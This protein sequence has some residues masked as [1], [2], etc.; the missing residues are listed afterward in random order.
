MRLL[1]ASTFVL[2]A[3]ALCGALRAQD[4]SHERGLPLVVQYPAK[5]HRGGSQLFSVAQHPSGRLYLGAL[6]G[7]LTYDG[8]SWTAHELPNNS[9]VFV[10]ATGRGGDVAIGGVGE[11]GLM[12]EQGVYRSLVP[13]L[14]A[15]QRE[16]GD[17]RGICATDYGFLFVTERGL[18]DWN[19]RAP[20]VVADFT[21]TDQPP[22]RCHQAG[23]SIYLAGGRG[24]YRVDA[25]T[26]RLVPWG[27]ENDRVEAVIAADDS[28]VVVAVQDKGLFITDG[29]LAI[30]FAPAA[31]DFLR[32]KRIS[33]GLR[34]RDGRLAISTRQ[35][36]IVI[37]RRDGTID[38]LIGLS[39]GISS[40]A[41]V[42]LAEDR[43]G[44]LWLA[45]HGP[46]E[47]IELSTAATRLDER[48]GLQ[49]HPHGI[50]RHGNALY[51]ATTHGL[52]ALERRDDPKATPVRAIPEVRGATRSVL[53]FDDQLLA[54]GSD[55]VAIRD[56]AG[57]WS[58]LPELK[59]DGVSSLLRST[60]DPAL[61]WVT[62]RTGLSAIRHEAGRWRHQGVVVKRPYIRSLLERDG[63]LWCGTIF[64]G[65]LR[66][67]PDGTVT[68]IGKGETE[69][70]VIGGQLVVVNW[71]R[72][73]MRVSG[74]TLLPDPRLTQFT[75]EFMHL[76]EDAAGNVWSGQLP[77]RMARKL[78][79]GSYARELEPLDR[80]DPAAIATLDAEPDGVIWFGTD[81]GLFRYDTRM[82]EAAAMTQA[83]VQ[84]APAIHRAVTADD[85]QV[86]G[87]LPASFGRLHIEFAPLSYRRG[88]TYQ[89]R[90]DPVD[91]AWS[92]P[93]GGSF[94]DYTN[95]GAG[96]YTFR[97]RASSGPGE[98]SAETQ[99]K[100]SVAPAWYRTPWALAL[101]AIVIGVLVTVI[102]RLR[103][104]ALHRQ[105]ERLR[106]LVDDRTEEMQQANA[107][108]E[109]LSLLDD[110]TAIGNRR[111]FQR[112][113]VEDWRTALKVQEPLALLILDLDHFKLLND[114]HGHPAGDAALIQVGRFLAR[115]IR[116]SGELGSRL[117][118]LVAR[119]GGEEFAIVLANTRQDEATRIAESLRSGLA[120]LD[121]DLGGDVT[122]LTASFGV[123]AVVPADA[124]GWE[125]LVHSADRALYA[126]KAAGRNCVRSIGDDE[127]TATP[128]LINVPQ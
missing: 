60:R 27:F 59:E 117:G 10:A 22:K 83:A 16:V 124:E 80:V 119:I 89:Y 114:E 105:A 123:A 103:T 26:N 106:A 90:L 40:A 126:A 125:E 110:L 4:R 21:R 122:R 78:A 72:G 70:T 77:P 55:G 13:Q 12:N 94:I 100:F 35:D 66:V 31:S 65:V 37:L 30:P 96:D 38:Q 43:E 46:L 29:V 118:D 7:V 113:L 53:S 121:I 1:R 18:I 23:R 39:A 120:S 102:V 71:R 20:H 5:T 25:T 107:Q 15:A 58:T 104:I 88:I 91:T 99:W 112:A 74:D 19:G 34:L 76:V 24:L 62:T 109:R 67:A 75:G 9:A 54:G 111:Y 48:S 82:A 8:A 81:E 52:F 86:T 28:R 128:L 57:R 116:R 6:R 63:V 44:T 101:W 49:G 69:V 64:D 95:L 98:P 115:R 87:V 79:N 127:G 108:L 3:L 73:A 97:L 33:D 17:V 41:L 47:A 51:I 42:D 32:N 84:P 85:R 93:A 92:E 2:C 14:P 11:M 50:A 36:G 61:V 45:H 56:A 68:T